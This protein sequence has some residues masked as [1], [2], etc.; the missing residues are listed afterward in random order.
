LDEGQ[1]GELHP[2]SEL[3]HPIIAKATEAFSG[4]P[5]ADNHSGL[6]V[7]STR[8]RLMEIRAGQWRGGVW[9]DEESGIHWLV[10]AGL[11]KGEHQD[12]DDFYRRVERENGSGGDAAWLPTVEDLRLLKQE[13]AS[14]LITV[15][16]LDV[17]EAL[18]D[19][20]REIQ[21][22][23][24]SRIDIHHP[25]RTDERLCAV[26]VE[27]VPVRDV[28]YEADEI[29]VEILPD[30]SYAGSDLLWQLTLRVL[31]SLNPPEHGW[32]RY[33]DTYSTIAEP[34]YFVTR[35]AT[36]EALVADHA[37]AESVEGDHAHYAH[38]EHLAGSTIEG[39]AVR[40]LCGVYFVPTRDHDSLPCCPTC[41]DRFDDLPP[42]PRG[43]S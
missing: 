8:L 34:G 10:V 14:R 42:G 40:A 21:S 20:L 16:E 4:D 22:G 5:A 2:L 23:G 36:L 18:L 37:L 31:I 25:V 26:E 27:V 11:A 38:R 13:T 19:V 30:R 39:K 6:I 35:G 43:G 41:R 15:W 3:P 24:I 32:D 7:S 1:L 12:R 17:Q 29:T 9:R 33:K 28:N